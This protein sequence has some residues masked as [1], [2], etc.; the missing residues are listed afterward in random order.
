[1]ADVIYKILVTIVATIV[2]AIL[3]WALSLILRLPFVSRNRRNLIQFFGISRGKQ[4]LFVYLS[5]IFVPQFTSRDFRGQVRSFSG[6][7]TP[8]AELAAITPVTKLFEDAFL[9]NLP[10]SIRA[11][12]SNSVHWSFSPIPITVLPS[13]EHADQIQQGAIFTIGSEAYNSVTDLYTRS[14]SPILRI[15]QVGMSM[16]IKVTQG[17]RSGEVFESRVNSEDDLAIVEK[18]CDNSTHTTIFIAAGLGVVGT[19]GAVYF[20]ANNWVELS[21]E[22]GV[23]PFAVC[24]RFQNSQSDP[25]AARRP[26]ELFRFQM[27]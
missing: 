5:T 20:I 8:S 3:G 25:N 24:L 22:F 10:K 6:P 7:A 26:I 16:S 2:L 14:C 23:R 13:P 17:A 27:P 1:M 21:K 11:W 12:L 19:V 15:Q 4:I 18:L 9:D